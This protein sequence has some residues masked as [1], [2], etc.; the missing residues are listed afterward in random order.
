MVKCCEDI[1]NDIGYEKPCKISTG[2]MVTYI[3]YVFT[4]GSTRNK[5]A[6]ILRPRVRGRKIEVV[7]P[8]PHDQ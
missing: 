3:F 1:S 4:L 6:Y 5:V 2:N 8:N 7:G